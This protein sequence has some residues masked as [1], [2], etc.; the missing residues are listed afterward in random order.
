MTPIIIGITTALLQ[1]LA[2]E[3]LKQFNKSSIYALTLSGIGFLYVGFTWTDT[4]TLIITAIQA[5]I[6][7]FI[8]YYGFAKSLY[9]LAAGYFLHGLWD[10]LYPF[11][12]DAALIP[13]HYD[14][15]CSSLDF[16]VGFY[17]ILKAYKQN[18]NLI[19]KNDDRSI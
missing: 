7:L 15:F 2:F 1:I 3:F 10:I 13:P 4:T 18:T 17:L 11:W 14:W 9:L 16:T 12:Q 8:A 5:I 6:F 19:S